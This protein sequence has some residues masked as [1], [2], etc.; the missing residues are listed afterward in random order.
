M[1]EDLLASGITFNDLLLIGGVDPARTILLRH[2]VGRLDVLGI[3]RADRERLERYQSRQ[4]P[5]CFDGADYVAVFLVSHDGR[6]TFG[7][8][9]RVGESTPVEVGTV[10]PLTAE[11]AENPVVTYD[12][13]VVPAF[14]YLEDRL[15][16]RWYRGKA[17]PGWKQ[18]AARNPKP[19]IEIATQ[20]EKPFPGWLAF[21]CAV[22][23]LDDLPRTWRE[24][25]RST[26]GVYLLTDAVGRHYVGSAKGGDGFLGRWEQYRGSRSGG[27][28]GL[29]AD[30]VG[31][32]SATVLQ[33]FD[34]STSDQTVEMVESQWK[35]KLGARLIGLNRN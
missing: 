34:L 25:L 23:D 32:F 9:Y 29:A 12:L 33:T 26:S 5:G 17:H 35:N 11:V 2:R 6:E 7:G 1:A 31:P 30:A 18:W 3:W 27:N 16:I 19:V 14:A 4:R 20:Q 8:L 21:T 10:D 24:V 22:D 13:Q 28:V 15:V